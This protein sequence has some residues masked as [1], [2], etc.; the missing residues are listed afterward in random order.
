M[1]KQSVPI[2]ELLCRALSTHIR[3]LEKERDDLY[4]LP[5]DPDDRIT[6][7]N[8]EID[9]SEKLITDFNFV[10]KHK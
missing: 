5:D 9:T 4:S 8:Q 1:E 3:E 6:N 10:I 7:I 2:M